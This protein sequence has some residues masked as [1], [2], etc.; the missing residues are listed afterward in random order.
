MRLWHPNT[1]RE[2]ARPWTAPCGPSLVTIQIQRLIAAFLRGF[3]RHLYTDLAWCYDLVAWMASMGQWWSWQ[4]TA[5]DA[6]PSGPVLELGHGTGHLQLELHR[7]GWS[8][9]GIDL[10]PQMLRISS[11]RLRRASHSPK[12]V[13]A[14]AQELPFPAQAF[15]GIVSTFPSEYILDPV[16]VRETHRI[17]RPG[18]C[19]VIAP[20]ALITGCRLGDRLARWLTCVTH[21]SADFLTSPLESCG[22]AVCTE[23]IS[24]PR[25]RVL[26]IIATKY[27][28]C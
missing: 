21:Q 22:Y 19:L 10:S 16:T 23:V 20:S 11:R 27:G 15:S 17:L 3:F 2:S 25:A 12:L 14:K 9:V 26:R 8:P 24:Q 7:R 1:P 13:R 18:G 4:R 6:L 28:G 5:L